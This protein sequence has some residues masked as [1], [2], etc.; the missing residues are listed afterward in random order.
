MSYKLPLR[1]IRQMF[2]N[3]LREEKLIMIDPKLSM[4]NK[5]HTIVPYLILCEVQICQSLS[6]TIHVKS[7]W[8]L[9][10]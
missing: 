7:V 4:V 5:T 3:I 2:N 10:L 1:G 9:A 6:S 8:Y